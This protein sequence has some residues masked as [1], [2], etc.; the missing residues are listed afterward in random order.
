[1]PNSVKT[2][3]RSGAGRTPWPFQSQLPLEQ[4]VTRVLPLDERSPLAGVPVQGLLRNNTNLPR[5]P[6]GDIPNL[7]YAVKIF[8]Q[9]EIASFA[10][11]R[12]HFFMFFIF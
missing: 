11:I 2:V 5:L 6:L 8:P 12:D 4:L 1:M 10:K 9:I 7:G 3:F